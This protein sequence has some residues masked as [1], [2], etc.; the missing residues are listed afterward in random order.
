MELPAGGGAPGAMA[1]FTYVGWSFKGSCGETEGGE[2]E[3][4]GLTL[5]GTMFTHGEIT[6]YHP[7]VR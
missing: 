2:N 7:H 5:G 1:G 6:F 3:R 4:L